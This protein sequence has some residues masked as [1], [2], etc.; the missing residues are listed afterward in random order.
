ME[1]SLL[2]LVRAREFTALLLNGSN[3]VWLI[4]W[5]IRD[6]CGCSAIA[7]ATCAGT[8][9]VDDDLSIEILDSSLQCWE[10]CFDVLIGVHRPV[11][12]ALRPGFWEVDFDWSAWGIAGGE[13]VREL[14]AIFSEAAAGPDFV[15]D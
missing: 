7:G 12:L 2:F 1:G 14:L 5:A 4:V 13:G 9:C 6:D 3:S 11:S 8:I 10:V 15:G